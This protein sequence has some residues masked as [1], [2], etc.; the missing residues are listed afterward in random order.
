MYKLYELESW[1]VSA[2]LIVHGPSCSA[3]RGPRLEGI[4]KGPAADFTGMSVGISADLGMLTASSSK[5]ETSALER[6]ALLLRLALWL[7]MVSTLRREY[8]R[9]RSRSAAGW[10]I[11]LATDE[12]SL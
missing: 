7:E 10:A 1:G 12:G 11:W 5:H 3:A 2:T 8:D 4:D 9:W 6:L